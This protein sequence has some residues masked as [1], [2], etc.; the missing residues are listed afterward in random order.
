[1][2]FVF[3]SSNLLKVL[4]LSLILNL[5]FDVQNNDV[6]E[7]QGTLESIATDKLRKVLSIEEY[8]GKVVIV[9]DTGIGFNRLNGF[10]GPY[11]KH[12]LDKLSSE[13]I[14]NICKET[15]NFRASKTTVLGIG[16]IRK[17]G[18]KEI[19]VMKTF[20]HRINGTIVEPINPEAKNRFVHVF[21]P[22][23]LRNGEFK[24][25][26]ILTDYYVAE[27]SEKLGMD[28]TLLWPERIRKKL[29][30]DKLNTSIEWLDII[31]KNEISARGLAGKELKRF[32]RED[33]FLNALYEE[34]LKEQKEG[35]EDE[36]VKR[37]RKNRFKRM[38]ENIGANEKRL[39]Y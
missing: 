20:K 34:D 26:N 3:V 31:Y 5:H 17:E 33:P 15:N 21:S 9:D 13:D 14:Y 39:C 8:K 35:W 36:I 6:V 32:I 23:A 7:I 16:Y 12:F 18:Q 4:E 19:M 28:V 10:P 11:G 38:G 37:Y 30:E 24:E 2:N 27:M 1:M 25:E 29:L 22:D